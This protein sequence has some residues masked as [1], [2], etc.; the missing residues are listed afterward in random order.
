MKTT[1]YQAAILF[2][3]LFSACSNNKNT[4]TPPATV[5]PDT[6]NTKMV[7]WLTTSDE[8]VL[9]KRQAAVPFVPGVNSYPV[10]EIDTT[11]TFQTMDGFGY[12]LT[13][14]SAQ[15]MNAMPSD[16]KGKLLQELLVKQKILYV[17]VI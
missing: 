13:G 9:L 5:A 7:F 10:I 16:A 11:K 4:I 3:A 14:G 12:T 2:I 17:S 6:S 8:S 15:V 1:N